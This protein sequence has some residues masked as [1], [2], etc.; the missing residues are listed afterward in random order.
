M[1]KKITVLLTAA[2][3]L[4]LAGT[5]YASD[6]LTK[7]YNELAKADFGTMTSRYEKINDRD[8]PYCAPEGFEF[9]SGAV[10]GK[11]A[12]FDAD[13]ADELLVFY[14]SHKLSGENSV[15][16]QMIEET[17]GVASLADESE[18]ITNFLSGE[19]G[20][21]CMF[22]KN[23]N[24]RPRIFMQYT[25]DGADFRIL[26]LDY[27]G[28]GFETV[29]DYS[30]VGSM[31]SISQKE[32][33]A[34][35][36]AGLTGVFDYFEP[37]KDED[38]TT[39]YYFSPYYGG[40]GNEEYGGFNIGAL[41]KDKEMIVDILTSTNVFDLIEK[42]GYENSMEHIEKEGRI[43]LSVDDKTKIKTLIRYGLKVVFNGEPMK[44]DTA[45][46]IEDGTTRVPMR[47]IF[48]ALG[49]QVEW[50]SE[51]KTVT[52]EKDGTKIRLTIGGN[53]A[54][55]NGSECALN[56]PAQVKNGRTMVPLRFVSEALGAKVGW[57]GETKTVTIES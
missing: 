5:A 3:T 55:I 30:G 20:G 24:G 19:K 49:A 32:A 11:I 21:G 43:T 6:V 56:A 31:Y 4:A 1:K 15:Y 8:Y 52:A 14:A 17:N 44:F 41:E 47:A 16:A 25:G 28:D 40:A 48:E 42:Y 12:D 26:D 29:F 23:V 13:G 39:E 22:V 33:D 7:T 46:Y 10:G 35:K 45:P 38:G 2:M 34:F 37:H 51:D 18:K 57:D 9:G 50:N 36:E 54:Y 53:T 27:N